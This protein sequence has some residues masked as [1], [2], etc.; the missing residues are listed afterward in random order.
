MPDTTTQ[1]P[2]LTVTHHHYEVTRTTAS[3]IYASVY[4]VM[5]DDELVHTRYT[6]YEALQWI[7]GYLFRSGLTPARIRRALEN[8]GH[9]MKRHSTPPTEFADATGNRGILN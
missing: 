4:Q 9:G 6:R 1:I 5:L 8:I 7:A 3:G 2:N